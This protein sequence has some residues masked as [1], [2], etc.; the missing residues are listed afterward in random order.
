M[1]WRAV[2]DKQWDLIKQHLPQRRRSRKGG[3]PPID[4]RKCFELKNDILIQQRLKN[5]NEREKCDSMASHNCRSR[6]LSS[7][8]ESAP[9][10]DHR[11]LF[12]R[13]RDIPVSW[14]AWGLEESPPPASVLAYCDASP[15]SRAQN[16]GRIRP[17]DTSGGDIVAL[18]T[19]AQ[20]DLLGCPWAGGM[21]GAPSSQHLATP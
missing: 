12:A 21:V 8:F 20:G 11:D 3:R 5:Q 10:D 15:L 18:A 9:Y 2:S 19:L 14:Y 6:C 4:D 16:V 1:A 7:F 17:L 13:F